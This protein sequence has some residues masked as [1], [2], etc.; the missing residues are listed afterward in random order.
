MKID[1]TYVNATTYR[2]AERLDGTVE[3]HIKQS[4]L[5]SARLL[6]KGWLPCSP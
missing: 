2:H 5:V 3:V 4:V 1:I 6:W